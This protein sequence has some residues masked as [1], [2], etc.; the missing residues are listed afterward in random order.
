[1][2]SENS[3]GAA[4]CKKSPER[5]GPSL[6]PERTG[7]NGQ[8]DHQP[9]A[10]PQHTSTDARTAVPLKI[11][12]ADYAAITDR[13]PANKKKNTATGGVVRKANENCCNG[14]MNR[15]ANASPTDTAIAMI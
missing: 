7:G 11:R 14:R 4:I 5:F 8:Y 3:N 13:P 10:P 15:E 9:R 6:N 2:V 12:T 1:M